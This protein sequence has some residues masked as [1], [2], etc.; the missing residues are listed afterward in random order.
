LRKN[1]SLD[2][3]SCDNYHSNRDDYL[4]TQFYVGPKIASY[5]ASSLHLLATLFHQHRARYRESCRGACRV[6]FKALRKINRAI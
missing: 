2:D 4:R 6:M 3:Y 5:L 1:V